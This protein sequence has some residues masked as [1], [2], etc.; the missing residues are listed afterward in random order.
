MAVA[1]LCAESVIGSLC[2]EMDRIR[3]RAAVVLAGLIS[4]QNEGLRLRLRHEWD[5][6]QQRRASILRL[7]GGWRGS[8]CVDPLCVEFLMEVCRRPLARGALR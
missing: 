2:R 5:Q 3:G 6:L 4:C 8:A 7:A 1:S